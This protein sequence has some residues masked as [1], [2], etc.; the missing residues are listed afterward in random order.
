M[1]ILVPNA[2]ATTKA[3]YA[4]ERPISYSN[5]PFTIAMD[6]GLLLTVYKNA[7]MVYS[8]ILLITI[9]MV[10]PIMPGVMMGR[11]TF[12]KVCIELALRLFDASI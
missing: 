2:N 1:N 12:L 4:M 11:T 10:P 9:N 6:M 3:P 5:M 8:P 7:E